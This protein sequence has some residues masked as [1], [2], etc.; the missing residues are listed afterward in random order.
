[1]RKIPRHGL[2]RAGG[3]PPA[4]LPTAAG[5]LRTYSPAPPS[6]ARAPSAHTGRTGASGRGTARRGRARRV[7][8]R[9]AGEARLAALLGPEADDAET[10]VVV[11]VRRVVV[12]P[13]RGPKDILVVVLRTA[14]RNRIRPSANTTNPQKS[15]PPAVGPQRYLSGWMLNSSPRTNAFTCAPHSR[16]C[17]LSSP[18]RIKSST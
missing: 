13:V 4:H 7:L 3:K 10:D 18:K 2:G 11:L 12:V 9:R 17:A 6:L 16:T 14:P 1:M 15:T 5:R 8:A